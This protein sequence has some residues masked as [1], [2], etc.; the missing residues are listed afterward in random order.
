MKTN[1]IISGL[2]SFIGLA[3]ALI[4]IPAL[5]IFAAGNPIPSAAQLNDALTLPDFGGR[6]LLGTILPCI[7]WLLW[8]TFALSVLIQ[9][10]YSLRGIRAPKI[11]G[12][13]FQ[14]QAAATLIGAVLIMFA[15]TATSATPAQASPTPTQAP[16]TISSTLEAGPAASAGLNSTA[17]G[18][19][20]S[21]TPAAPT[22]TVEVNRGDTLWSIA[23]ST[24]GDGMR[25]TEIVELNLGA[26]QQD[27]M[28]LGADSVIQPGWKLK[29]P[30]PNPSTTPTHTVKA[31]ETLSGIAQET[32]G[33]AGK[34]TEIFDAS[35]NTEQADGTKLTNPDLIYPGWELTIP[36]A[37]AAAVGT[38]TPAPADQ[39]PAAAEPTTPQS[40]PITPQ[41]GPEAPASAQNAPE[42]TDAATGTVAPPQ[43]QETP[44]APAPVADPRFNTAPATPLTAAPEAPGTLEQ[45]EENDNNQLLATAGGIMGILAVGFLSVLG[46]KRARQARERKKGEVPA[47]PTAAEFIT[48]QEMAVTAFTDQRNGIN[49]AVR[50]LASWAAQS[51]VRLPNLMALRLT[52]DTISFY[53]NEAAELPLPFRALVPDNTAWSITVD[54]AN[55]LQSQHPAP[56]PALVSLGTDGQGG[57]LLIDLENIGALAING[58]HELTQGAIMAIGAELALSPW[59]D[60]LQVTMVGTNRDLPDVMDTGRIRH[61]E[62][63]DQL[64]ADLEGRARQLD[65]L[66]NTVGAED[67]PHARSLGT[68]SEN[69]IPEI[70]LLAEEPPAHIKDKLA[71]LVE[72]IPRVGIATVTNGHINGPWKL[73]ITSATEAFLEPDQIP[74]QPQIVSPDEYANLVSSMRAAD[75]APHR[76][77][78]TLEVTDSGELTVPDDL[79][80]LVP[81]PTVELS[82]EPL[83]DPTEK[84]DD[85][86]PQ[87][88]ILGSVKLL[89]PAGER[90]TT[91]SGG[92]SHL[93]RSTEILAYL[94]LNPGVDFRTFH[95]AMW[96]GTSPEEKIQTRNS[97]CSRA[98]RLLGKANPD[99]E[100]FPKVIPGEDVYGLHP[101]VHTDWDKFQALVPADPSKAPTEHLTQALDLVRGEP[102]QDTGRN[103]GW[104]GLL[105]LEMSA[106]IADVATTLWERAFN[107][108]DFETA[109]AAARQGIL[110]EPFNEDLHCKALRVAAATGNTSEA[111]ELYESFQKILATT[112]EDA[113]PALETQQLFDAI[114]AS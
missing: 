104:A 89:N 77:T 50:W 24:L 73:Q 38:A 112:D 22:I 2:A 36:T 60:D 98:R 68:Y 23:E 16:T 7:A 109:R 15:S 34:Y 59:A 25:Y 72:Q 111:S 100:Y 18:T 4:G 20:R 40:A 21:E 41:T 78:E 103:Y 110:A 45:T 46:I 84:F 66:L 44:A 62:D 81:A 58:P 11:P 26:T 114:R 105:R 30:A 3:I 65:K 88:N 80:N 101:A 86:A 74:V 99:E 76:V 55:K 108:G 57:L 71:V 51:E 79:S 102:F 28:S 56:Y 113:Q 12:F 48:E 97:A 14:Q 43:S 6:F 54:E 1:R 32:L 31:G 49:L 42:A 29:V 83:P 63:L 13:K 61:F 64:V 8:A 35:T 27:G 19:P 107:A 87:I 5:L 47:T 39:T 106:R 69:W 95:L 94:A 96:P 93:T 17:P 52:S 90:P 92:G 33:D 53:L 82:A 70:V 10:P 67:L 85:S 37:A 9:I 91:A 75:Q